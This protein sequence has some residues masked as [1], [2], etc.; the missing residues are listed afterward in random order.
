MSKDMKLIM[1]N[2]RNGSLV[3]EA[4]GHGIIG[5]FKRFLNITPKELEN[6]MVMFHDGMT[7]G[8][9]YNKIK[10]IVAIYV[11]WE[12][13]EWRKE[14]AKSLGIKTARTALNFVQ[15]VPI[16]GQGIALISNTIIDTVQA[17]EDIPKFL[18]KNRQV[19][20]MVDKLTKGLASQYVFADDAS[21]KKH[22]LAKLFNIHD[23]MEKI[24]NKNEIENF[25]AS[26]LNQ[27]SD[28]GNRNRTIANVKQ[29][30]SGA[31]CDYLEGKRGWQDCRPPYIP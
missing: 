10:T 15:L 27:L 21:A 2:Y 26:F 4:W 13:D 25:I 5:N 18:S 30:A 1:E 3:N 23:D 14:L 12:K 19:D 24:M 29:F 22:P 9:Y 11:M 28:S 31:L 8:D 6:P 16:L 7:Y 20:A 17:A